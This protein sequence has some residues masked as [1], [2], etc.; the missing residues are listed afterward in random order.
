MQSFVG[1]SGVRGQKTRPL[2]G[3][4]DSEDCAREESKGTETPLGRS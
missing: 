4:V 1:L 3:S 2:I